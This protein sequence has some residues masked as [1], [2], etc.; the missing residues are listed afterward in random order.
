MSCFR[1]LRVFFFGK[2]IGR[3]K[4]HIVVFST[5]MHLVDGCRKADYHYS[6]IEAYRD[7]RGSRLR[8]IAF[9]DRRIWSQK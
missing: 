8:S 1:L 6:E 9:L 5:H 3:G 4:V 2:E 7:S